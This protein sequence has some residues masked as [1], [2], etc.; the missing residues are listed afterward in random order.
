MKMKS[1]AQATHVVPWEGMRARKHRVKTAVGTFVIGGLDDLR[2]LTI[3]IPEDTRGR[4]AGGGYY[5][6]LGLTPILAAPRK[7]QLYGVFAWVPALTLWVYYDENDTQQITLLPE[8]LRWFHL[9]KDLCQFY[10]TYCHRTERSRKVLQTW[11]IIANTFVLV[12]ENLV[13]LASQIS[14][15]P[16]SE[17]ELACQVFVST[18]ERVLTCSPISPYLVEAYQALVIVY[19]VLA[20]VRIQCTERIPLAL[21]LD[22][23][24]LLECSVIII[25]QFKQHLCL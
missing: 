2:P 4:K 14:F 9:E 17:R 8:G 7:L 5:C 10:Q 20:D 11:W 3:A 22:V 18:Y 23:I 6:T 12:P 19:N 1:D 25:E 15:L 16:L 13:T 21:A 24:S